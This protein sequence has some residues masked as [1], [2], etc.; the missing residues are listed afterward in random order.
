MTRYVTSVD[1]TKIAFDHHGQGPPV[2]VVSGMF[3]DQIGRAHV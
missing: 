2:V 3:C 1:V